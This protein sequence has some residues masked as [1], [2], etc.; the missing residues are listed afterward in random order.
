MEDKTIP[1]ENPQ[2]LKSFYPHEPL[3]S[4]YNDQHVA[5]FTKT[6]DKLIS[7]I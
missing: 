5:H 2:G 4:I 7:R 3:V 1:D 6:I